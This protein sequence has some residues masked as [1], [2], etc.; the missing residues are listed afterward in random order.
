M[1]ICGSYQNFSWTCGRRASLPISSAYIVYSRNRFAARR[2]EPDGCVRGADGRAQRVRRSRAPGRQPTGD[3]WD[4]GRLRALFEDE[5]FVRAG[6]VMLPT[7]RAAALEAQVGQALTQLRAALAPQEAF[8]PASSRR[9]FHISGGD[10]AAMVILPALAAHLAQ[11]APLV[12]LRFRFIEKGA[13]LDLLDQ[14][15]LDLALGVFPEPPKRMAM[16]ALFEE[17]FVCLARHDHPALRQGL[18]LEIFAG[19]AASAGDRARRR[20][21]GGG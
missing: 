7:A 2:L 12:N 11:A 1:S 9:V 4:A 14:D 18:S 8:N 10:Y 16:R 5:L 21:G 3:E 15:A 19:A 20:G 17:R 13:A 6:R